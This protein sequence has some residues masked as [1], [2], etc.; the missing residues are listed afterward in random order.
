MAN[1]KE[2]TVPK[3]RPRPAVPKLSLGKPKTRAEIKES[4]PRSRPE[5]V[6]YEET[7]TDD[8][9]KERPPRPPSRPPMQVFED[10]VKYPKK[11]KGTKPRTT[12]PEVKPLQLG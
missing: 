11:K 2:A 5:V 10:K 1:K 3:T 8:L 12:P 9:V 4:R 7:R 6:E